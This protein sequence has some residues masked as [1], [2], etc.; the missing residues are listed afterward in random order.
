MKTLLQLLQWNVRMLRCQ[1][2]LV[3][4]RLAMM[5]WNTSENFIVHK[6]V[7]HTITSIVKPNGCTNASDLFYFGIHSTC[8]GWSFC[9]SSGVWDC[10]YR[11]RRLSNRYYW[12][13]DSGYLL[14]SRQR[15]LFDRCLLLYV[16]SQ[17]PDYGR[18]DHPKH[19]ECH[20]KMK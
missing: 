7:H 13:H 16:Q 19:A 2:Q 9:P 5:I 1:K 14:A 11:N 6:A 8:F 15:Y 20:S 3:L 4:L 10:T 12:L 17:T 18:E